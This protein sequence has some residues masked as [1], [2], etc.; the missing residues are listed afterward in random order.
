[1]SAMILYWLRSLYELARPDFKSQISGDLS[2][3]SVSSALTAVSSITCENQVINDLAL[4][5][6]E[7]NQVSNDLKVR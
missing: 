5:C 7:S 4:Y 2:F 6:M 3:I 1:M